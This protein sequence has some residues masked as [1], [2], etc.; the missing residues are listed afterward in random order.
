MAKSEARW[1]RLIHAI[2]NHH[3]GR[4]ESFHFFEQFHF[5]IVG[6]LRHKKRDQRFRTSN[7]FRTVTKLER[8]KYLGIGARG[9]GHL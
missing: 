3:G 8:M 2:R 5:R 1:A 7:G 6:S 4:V 9:L